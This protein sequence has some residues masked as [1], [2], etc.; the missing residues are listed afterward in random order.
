VV[1]RFLPG[2][3]E[4]EARAG[5]Q[6][7]TGYENDGSTKLLTLRSVIDFFAFEARGAQFARR[8]RGAA[9]AE[10]PRSAQIAES[11]KPLVDQTRVLIACMP[12][13]G[14]TFLSSALAKA[15]GMRR[16]PLVP[17]HQRREQELCYLALKAADEKTIWLRSNHGRRS[18]SVP[19]YP[20]GFV[21]QKHV[22]YS[23]PTAKIIEQFQIRTVVLVR[24]IFDVVPSVRDHIRR[25]SNYMPMGYITEEMRE[26]PDAALDDFISQLIIPWY[27]NFFLSWRECS[28]ALIISYEDI[29]R[30][31]HDVVRRVL[32]FAGLESTDEVV[33][34]A[35]AAT[36]EGGKTRKNRA[37]LGR[38]AEL[39]PE[40]RQRIFDYAGYYPDIDFSIIGIS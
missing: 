38:G 20:R 17:G 14:S 23:V 10:A 6:R 25:E 16:E 2:R 19:N 21:A 4:R 8:E 11:Q 36:E 40:V 37:V 35:V 34:D 29:N 33:A 39:N 13:S 5:L 7:Q 32:E 26:W 3:R 1:I 18:S 12:K 31:K 28:D 30:D 22:R 9:R 27:F 15:P 24:N